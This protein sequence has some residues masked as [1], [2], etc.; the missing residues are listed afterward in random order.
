[1]KPIKVI[2]G[3][4]SFYELE[5]DGEYKAEVYEVKGILIFDTPEAAEK[6]AEL[7]IENRIYD[8]YLIPT[9]YKGN[10]YF[11]SN[12]SINVLN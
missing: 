4:I 12:V 7:M 8:S 3:T 10:V 2:F 1:M 11:H 6:N 9:L 5:A